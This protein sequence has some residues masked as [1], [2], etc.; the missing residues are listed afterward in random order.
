[1]SSL[2]ALRSEGQEGNAQVAGSSGKKLTNPCRTILKYS[3]C[4]CDSVQ[5][6]QAT[7]REA[8]DRAGAIAIA[9]GEP[10]HAVFA[11]IAVFACIA[12]FA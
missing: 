5:E 4:S 3:I 7:H 1:M 10:S 9:A 2:H 11:S 6:M 12:V 8:L